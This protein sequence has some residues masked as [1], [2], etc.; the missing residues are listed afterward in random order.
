MPADPIQQ[1]NNLNLY[2][3]G[4]CNSQIGTIF[5]TIGVGNIV[6]THM[7]IASPYFRPQSTYTRCGTPTQV[8][9][10]LSITVL[11]RVDLCDIRFAILK[12][13]M[14]IKEEKVAILQ[15]GGHYYYLLNG[16]FSI[17]VKP[18]GSD[19]MWIESK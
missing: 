9:M 10:I 3:T 4:H 5:I 16:F 2:H 18:F 11:S 6:S 1:S 19:S 8:Q 13:F 17:I 7:C 14:I 12:I 15:V